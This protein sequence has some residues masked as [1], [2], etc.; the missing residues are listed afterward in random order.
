MDAVTRCLPAG[1]YTTFRTYDFRRRVLGLKSHLDR[2][3][4]PAHRLGVQPA[5]GR[6]PLRLQMASLLAKFPSPEARLRLILVTRAEPG[7]IYILL[8]PLKT[9]SAMIYTYGV[10]VIT[11]S[12]HR[13]HPALKSTDFIEESQAERQGLSS[14]SAYEGLLVRNSRILE[15]LTSNFFYVRGKSLGTV[16]RGVLAG[17]TRHQVLHLAEGQ[18]MSIDHHALRLSQ[19]EEIDEAFLTS[20][21]RGIVPIVTIDRQRVGSGK[22]GEWTR[23]LI[24]VY[25]REI[26][27]RAESILLADKSSSIWS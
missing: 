4:R 3:Y 11:T 19:V 6:F 5:V 24:A 22:V 10:R 7:L 21:S 23:K 8:E 20:S 12:A 25:N 15:G 13:D 18:G 26:E 27:R 2:L 17:V 1:L 14:S 16:R 9:P